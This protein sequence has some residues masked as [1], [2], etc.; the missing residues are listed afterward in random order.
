MNALAHVSADGFCKAFSF[1]QPYLPSQ[2]PKFFKMAFQEYRAAQFEL[3]TL[4][5][6]HCTKREYIFAHCPACPRPGEEGE[7]HISIDENFNLNRYKWAGKHE[8]RKRR[9]YLKYADSRILRD[10][11]KR[12]GSSVEGEEDGGCNRYFKAANKTKIRKKQKRRTRC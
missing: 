1:D 6:F 11:L 5:D 2:F 4:T 12:H 8:I 3:D 7:F 9:L 10:Y